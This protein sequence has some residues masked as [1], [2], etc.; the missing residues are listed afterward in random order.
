MKTAPAAIVHALSLALLFAPAARAAGVV[1]ANALVIR[2]VEHLEKVGEKQA[3]ADF[4]DRSKPFIEGELYVLVYSLDGV[5][6]AHGQDPKLVGQ[7]RL[8]VTDP[9]GRKY[10]AEMVA[11]AQTESKGV[12]DY[13]F[14][15]PVTGRMQP[16]VTVWRRPAGK[17]FVV[18]VG[19]YRD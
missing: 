4:Q 8:D 18:G 5:C 2:A 9:N 19:V 11:A 17:Q 3:F 15:N 6:L 10:I 14:K 13:V 12:I 1:D 16:K 7:K